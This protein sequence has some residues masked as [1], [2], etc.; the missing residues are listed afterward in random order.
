M[1]STDM[2]AVLHILR[3]LYLHIRTLE[4]FADSLVF[5][6]GQ[7]AVL[8][9]QTDSDRFKSFVRTVYVCSDKELMQIPSCSQVRLS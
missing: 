8:V 3:S 6:E 4:E 9:E 7:R 5:R 2:S 1:S